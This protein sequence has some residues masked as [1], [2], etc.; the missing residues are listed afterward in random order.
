VSDKQSSTER[1][2]EAEA[3]PEPKTEILRGA[4]AHAESTFAAD[5]LRQMGAGAAIFGE[6]VGP[7]L[8]AGAVHGLKPDLPGGRYS[9]AAVVA[10]VEAFRTQEVS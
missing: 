9:H 1:G 7:D 6:D 8:L 5:E 4:R 3:R 2:R 10:A